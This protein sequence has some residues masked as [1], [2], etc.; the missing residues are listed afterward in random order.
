MVVVIMVL[1]ASPA[2]AQS[3]GPTI[4]AGTRSAADTP[5]ARDEIAKFIDANVAKIATADA[6]AVAAGRD[7]LVAQLSPPGTAV[8]FQNAYCEVLAGRLL[9]ALDAAGDGDGK[10]ALV[11]LN[12]AIVAEKAARYTQS[13][14]LGSLVARLIADPAPQVALWGVKAASPLLPK[15]LDNPMG[16]RAGGEG[17]VPA[18]VAAA[19]RFPDNGPLAEEIYGTLLMRLKDPANAPSTFALDNGVPVVLPAVLE[20]VARR[21][22][23]FA[24]GGTTPKTPLAEQNAIVFVT[25]PEVWQRQKEADKRQTVKTLRDL[26]DATA[27][28]AAGLQGG[29]ESGALRGELITMLTRIGSGLET[30][31]TYGSG[32]GAQRLKR[33]A[34]LLRRLSRGTPNSDIKAAVD[35]VNSAVAAGYPNLPAATRPA[36]TGASTAGA[37]EASAAG[38]PGA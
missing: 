33:D 21:T 5:A 3:N 6:T 24:A 1:S 2:R 20:I 13:E 30:I 7:A 32:D 38:R 29:G 37:S 34:A 27:A 31:G 12:V 14:R 8:T 35:Q 28:S 17:T 23:E 4:S 15:L 36:E 10:A 25:H 11:R 16:A 22:G 19:R 9:A 26:M 18:I